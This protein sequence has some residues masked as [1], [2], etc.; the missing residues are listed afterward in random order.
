VESTGH[1]IIDL[2]NCAKNEKLGIYG[3]EPQATPQQLAEEI[4]AAEAEFSQVVDKELKRIQ[5][6]VDEENNRILELRRQNNNEAEVTCPIC[7]EVCPAIS[8]ESEAITF[9]TCCGV[10]CHRQCHSNWNKRTKVDPTIS[11]ACFHCR[12]YKS[13]SDEM[14]YLEEI[15]LTGST[16]SKAHAFNEIGVAYEEGTDGKE[17]NLKESLKCCEK[18]AELGHAGA[19]CKIGMM[20]WCGKFHEL[21]VPK[22]TEKAKHMVRRGVDQGHP[23]SQWVLGDFLQQKPDSGMADT[24]AHRL[25]ALSAYQGDI[26]GIGKLEQFYNEQYKN[27]EG[28]LNNSIQDSRECQLLSLYW[29]GR[30]CNKKEDEIPQESFMF[31]RAKFVAEFA[32]AMQML[33]HKRR[34]FDLDPLTGYS[35]IPFLASIASVVRK[36]CKHEEV[37]NVMHFVNTWRQMCATCGK[38]GDKEC[39]LK[40]CARCKAFFYCSK[41]CQV[42]HWKAGHKVDCKALHWIESYFP[43]IRTP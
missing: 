18:A 40:Q 1:L 30:L 17:R 9:M 5:V 23:R 31:Y 10:H 19:Q 41:E 37:K 6:F 43:N 29:T 21:S 8:V 34:C 3:D 38:Q 13:T 11:T 32:I 12:R 26:H 27:L 39:V 4:K 42:K 24:E 14:E 7:L 35:H 25:F 36:G 15:S 20:S 33:W 2:L 22:S 28:N 16:F